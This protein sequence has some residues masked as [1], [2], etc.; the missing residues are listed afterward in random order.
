MDKITLD[1][2]LFFKG[3]CKEA[4]EFYK[5]V[6]GG[7]LVL[8]TYGES[9]DGMDGDKDWIMHARLHGGDVQIMA[10]DT[11]KASPEAKKITLALGGKDEK[12]LREIFD[13]L[14]EGGKVISPLK[15]EF[16]GDIYGQLT[17]KF[18]IEWMVNI[19]KQSDS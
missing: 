2:Y 10:S 11:Q 8:S 14:S 17:D 13:G 9:P 15:K 6:F 16:W 3:E 4:M 1:V 19:S 5:S 12:R 18:G 7:K